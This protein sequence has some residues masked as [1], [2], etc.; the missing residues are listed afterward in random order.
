MTPS[1]P[2][3][4][5][6]IYNALCSCL[7]LDPASADA[8]KL[9]HEAYNEPENTPRPAR[10]VDI[11]YWSAE[12]DDSRPDPVSYLHE[13]AITSGKVST[14]VM[15]PLAYNLRV[16]CY[17]SNSELNAHR[18]RSFIYLDGNNFPRRILRKAG[19]YPVK[20]PPKPMFMFEPEGSLWRRRTDVIIPLTVKDE[21][22]CGTLNGSI[23]EIPGVIIY[24]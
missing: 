21:A 13:A 9:I 17:G 3:F 14:T 19:I 8:R 2:V 11:I 12:P 1:D 23:Q 15:R 5:Q 7:N 18:I 4:K 20:D 24:D 10:T 16:V 22:V 6:A